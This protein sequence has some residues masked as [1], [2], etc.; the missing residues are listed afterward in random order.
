[1]GA[2]T[3]DRHWYISRHGKRYGPY[4]FAALTEAAAKGVVTA[5]TNVWRLGW[6]SWHPA[7]QVPGLIEEPAAANEFAEEGNSIVPAQERPDGG[8]EAAAGMSQPQ[9]RRQEHRVSAGESR[10]AAADDDA[11][12]RAVTGDVRQTVLEDAAE[13]SPRDAA[14][15]ESDSVESDGD[16]SDGDESEDRSRIA[17]QGARQDLHQDSGQDRLRDKLPDVQCDQAETASPDT[18]ADKPPGPERPPPPDH[19]SATAALRAEREEAPEHAERTA[20]DTAVPAVPPQI[21]DGLPEQTSA[22]L[23]PRGVWRGWKAAFG[24]SVVVL[25]LV[26]G[27]LWGL[28]ASGAVIV[29][30]PGW[31]YSSGEL[32]APLLPRPDDAAQMPPLATGDNGQSRA[33]AAANLSFSRESGGG[34]SLSSETALAPPAGK[35]PLTET[36]ER[37]LPAAVAALPAVVALR[38]TAPAAFAKFKQRFGEAAANA[39]DGQIL[40][41][42]RAALRKSVK[43]QLANASGETLV[44]I[45]E[46]YLGYMQTLQFSNPE[47]CVALSDDTKGANL[48]LNIEKGFPALFARE[49]AVLERVAGIDPGTVV[50]ALT[51]DEAQPSLETVFAALRSQPVQSD[52]LGRPRLAP[53]EFLPYCRLV[54]AFYE[55]VLALPAEQRI[56]L[57]RYL[58]AAAA[59]AEDDTQAK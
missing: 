26:A 18:I 32:P 12:S 33:S 3:V 30:V 8:A 9:N 55:D 44:E 41:L 22:S 31:Q 5:D 50:A 11:T 29:I 21:R 47:S 1:M 51:A 43:R 46:A 59:N 37:G 15:V 56:N 13:G 16:E 27:T 52:L 14:R 2:Q 45:T 39:P 57:L 19:D 10:D 34:P 40:A 53:A 20:G 58:Y 49:M 25:M 42:A 7:W 48:T 17:P 38:R 24:A 28:L 35:A 54:I 23:P 36:A 6:V 4:T